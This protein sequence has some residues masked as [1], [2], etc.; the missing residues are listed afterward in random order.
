LEFVAK[1]IL[2]IMQPA[3]GRRRVD[4]DL[5]LKTSAMWDNVRWLRED[6]HDEVDI[7]HVISA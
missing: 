1:G 4:P 6:M 3:L 2:D 5:I 7:S